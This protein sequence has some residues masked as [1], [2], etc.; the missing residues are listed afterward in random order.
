M[1]TVTALALPTI[2]GFLVISVV[3]RNDTESGFSMR[4]SLAYPLG[5]GLLTMQMFL[6]A[7]MRVPLRLGYVASLIVIE[8]VGL[9][10]LIRK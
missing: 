10:L 5:M 9:F 3:L 8:I 4:L 2:I 6:L 7:L 1:M